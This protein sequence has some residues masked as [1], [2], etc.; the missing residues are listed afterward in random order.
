MNELIFNSYINEI[1]MPFDI[2]DVKKLVQDQVS[3]KKHK[4]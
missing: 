4:K 3:G 1:R 2:E